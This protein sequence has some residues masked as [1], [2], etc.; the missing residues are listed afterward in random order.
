[1]ENAVKEHHLDLFGERLSCAGFAANEVRRFRVRLA[2]ACPR[3][4]LFAQVHRQ[5][6]AWADTG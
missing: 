2:S 5:L 6:H 1:M 3:Q 4:Q